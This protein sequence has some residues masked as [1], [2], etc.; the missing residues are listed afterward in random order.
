MQINYSS[1]LTP[2]TRYFVLRERSQS[3]HTQT[4]VPTNIHLM[5]NR[6]EEVFPGLMSAIIARSRNVAQGALRQSDIVRHGKA[7]GEPLS[8]IKL[9]GFGLVSTFPDWVVK[10]WED[11]VVQAKLVG[12]ISPNHPVLGADS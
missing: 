10:V 12:D 3:S 6:K 9:N 4:G 7:P 8:P 11:L 2:C 1:M 5:F